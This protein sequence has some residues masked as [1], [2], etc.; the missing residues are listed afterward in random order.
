MAANAALMITIIEM[1]MKHGLPAVLKIIQSWNFSG[2][3]ITEEDILKL[4]D[5]MKDPRS[6]FV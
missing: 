2:E 4:K 5:K 6:Y 3:E 1:A